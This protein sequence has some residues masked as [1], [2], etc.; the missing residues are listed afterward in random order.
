MARRLPEWELLVPGEGPYVGTIR[1][2]DEAGRPVPIAGGVAV[3]ACAWRAKCLHCDWLGSTAV[4]VGSGE[5]L[6]PG[7]LTREKLEEEWVRHIYRVS[8]KAAVLDALEQL[9]RLAAEQQALTE[10]V[11][12]GVRRLRAEGASWAQVGEL[13]GMTRQSAWEH[14]ADSSAARRH[15]R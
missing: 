14:W 6:R 7:R 12:E 10:V 5:A 4:R 8:A 1:I 9:D 2:E 11:D 13:V 3:G 15:R